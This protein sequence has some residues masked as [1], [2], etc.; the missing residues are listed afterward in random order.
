MQDGPFDDLI[1]GSGM[2]GLTVAGLLAA[3]GRRVL[4]ISTPSL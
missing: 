4:K 1:I 3:E 2:A